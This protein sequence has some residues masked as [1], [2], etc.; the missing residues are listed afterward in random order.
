[1]GTTV[2]PNYVVCCATATGTSVS[3]A[4]PKRGEK[5][6]SSESRLCSAKRSWYNSLIK[7]DQAAAVG[8]D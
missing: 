6:E 1:M 4:G 5:A 3:T 8:C 2:F 7:S